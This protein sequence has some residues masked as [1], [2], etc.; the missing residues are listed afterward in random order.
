MKIAL[1][2]ESALIIVDVQNDFLPGGALPVPEGDRV[3]NPINSYI[4][5]FRD[6]N[7][8]IVATRDWHPPNHI[9]FRER[10]G[11]WPPH[12]IKNTFGAEY[13][14]KLKLPG[15]IIIIS[16]GFNEDEEA[17]SGFHNTSLDDVLRKAGI[18]RI[19]VSGLAT[20]Y[21]VK[22]TALDGLRLG[23]QVVLLLDAIKGV[24]VNPGDSEKAIREII[25]NGGIAIEYEDIL[26]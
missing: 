14:K 25:F 16:K 10:G 1:T 3:I 9:S 12:C 17:Y 26:L 11:P 7:R 15:D 23:Y 13:P 19:F 24:D 18:R 6:K 4:K 20:D 21:C 5:L 8:L 2:K 22:A